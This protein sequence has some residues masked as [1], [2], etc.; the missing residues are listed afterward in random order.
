MTVERL[1]TQLQSLRQSAAIF[2]SSLLGALIALPLSVDLSPG[3][4]GVLVL[5]FAVLGLMIG[6]RRRRSAAFFY[7]VLLSVFLLSII[8][9][10]SFL[11]APTAPQQVSTNLYRQHKAARGYGPDAKSYAENETKLFN[12]VF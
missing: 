2:L 4:Q 12:L 3:P 1:E 5:V 10:T 9:S 11:Q 6:F 8:L 7:F